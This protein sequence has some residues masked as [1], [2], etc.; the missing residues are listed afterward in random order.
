M[1]LRA[2]AAPSYLDQHGEPTHSEQLSGRLCVVGSNHPAGSYWIFGEAENAV[3]ADVT[4]KVLVDSA[5]AAGEL[6]LLG[7]GIRCPFIRESG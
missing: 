7:G 6:T 1:Y 2:C 3:T 5:R 4:A